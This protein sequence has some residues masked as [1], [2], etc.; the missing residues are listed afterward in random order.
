MGICFFYGVGGYIMLLIPQIAYE[1]QAGGV[2][3]GAVSSNMMLLVGVGTMTGN[4]LA[5]LLSRRGVELGLAPIGGAILLGTLVVMG[6]VPPGGRGFDGLLVLAGFSTGFFL[7]PLYAFIQ[8]RAGNHRRG[9]ILAGVSL[10]DSLAGSAV[11]V[12]YPLLAAD[13]YLAW[14]PHTQLLLLAGITFAMLFYGVWHI[15]HHTVCAI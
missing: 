12:I 9:R 5:G 1:L 8:Q 2:R 3:T 14:S 10:L 11:S 15:P 13:R 6:F 7:V 4:L